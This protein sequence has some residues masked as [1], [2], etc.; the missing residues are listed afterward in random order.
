MLESILEPSKLID[1]KYVTYLVE[2]KDGRVLSGLL[3]GRDEKEVVL[4]DAQNKVL[5]L[6]VSDVEQLVT[7][8]QSLMPEL[9]LRDMTAQQVAD[10]L[11]YLGSLK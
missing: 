6:P 10:L 7:Q 2:T 1:P 3:A 4:K 11:E 5:R 8:Q 9:L